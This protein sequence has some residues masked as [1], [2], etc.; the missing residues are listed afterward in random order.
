MRRPKEITVL[1]ELQERNSIKSQ[2]QARIE[3]IFGC[4]ATSTGGKF[5]RKIGIKGIKLGGA[6]KS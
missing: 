5:T 3:H 1:V 4:F 6:K 2:I